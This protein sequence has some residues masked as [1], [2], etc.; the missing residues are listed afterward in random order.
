MQAGQV[1]V[2]QGLLHRDALGGVKHKHLVNQVHSLAAQDAR[3][4]AVSTAVQRKRDTKGG[5]RT[6]MYKSA[7]QVGQSGR[8]VATGD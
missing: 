1:W 8:W 3:A 2:L 6:S 5:R 4:E 7:A